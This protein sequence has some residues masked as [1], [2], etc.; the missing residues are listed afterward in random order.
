MRRNIPHFSL[1]PLF[2]HRCLSVF[3]CGSLFLSICVSA[4]AQRDRGSARIDGV[5]QNAQGKPV[6]KA[7][8]QLNEASGR[9]PRAARTDSEGRFRFSNLPRGIYNLRASAQGYTEEWK[10]DNLLRDGQKLSLSVTLTAAPSE[11]EKKPQSRN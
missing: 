9:V 8:V 6:V 1:K 10:K 7:L 3:I 5:V 4:A 2:S 11:P